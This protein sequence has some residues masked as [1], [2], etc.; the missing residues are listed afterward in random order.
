MPNLP[1]NSTLN[2]DMLKG[3]SGHLFSLSGDRRTWAPPQPPLSTHGPSIR[4]RLSLAPCMCTGISVSKPRIFDV[5]AS[6][7]RPFSINRSPIPQSPRRLTSQR[8]LHA[9]L[10]GQTFL[11]A[12]TRSHLCLTIRDLYV[13]VRSPTGPHNVLSEAR[14]QNVSLKV[15]CLASRRREGVPNAFR[16]VVVEER[17]IYGR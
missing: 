7:R 4:F 3:Q 6:R 13:P 5:T 11:S 16:L 12:P 2:R 15:L 1:S 14:L 10:A 17:N 9:T 8:W